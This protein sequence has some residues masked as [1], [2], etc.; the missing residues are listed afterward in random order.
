MVG[1]WRSGAPIDITPTVDDPS[2]GADPQRNNNFNYAHVGSLITS[3]QSR[4]PFAAHIRKSRPRSDELNLNV[5]NQG[6]R[7]GIPYGPEVSSAETTSGTTS[8]LRGLA[9]GEHTDPLFPPN[10]E[11][12]H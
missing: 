3:D 2:L 8:Q 1:R 7:G 5:L 10:C 9:F 4:C 12:E 6:I 11:V